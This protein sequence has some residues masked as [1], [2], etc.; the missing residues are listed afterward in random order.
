MQYEIKGSPFPV[1]ICGVNSGETIVCQKGA[2]TW[3]SSNMH[4][5]TNVGSS[6]GK[7]FGKAM[8]GESIFQNEYTA[9][10][11]F[12]E[13]AFGSSVPG[14]ILPIQISPSRTI[15]AQKT[16]FLASEK[17]VNLEVF[18]QKKIGSGFFGGEGFIMQKFSGNG[19]LFIEVDGSIIEYD[20]DPGESL[21]VDTGY[22]CA[23]DASVSIDVEMIKGVGNALFGGE[24]LF[25]TRVTGPGHVWLQ[26]MPIPQLAS[27]LRP[28][29]PTSNG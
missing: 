19:M 5:V 10:G 17:S 11:G 25:N 24:G 22:L 23:M 7:L 21:L 2:M 1:V 12:G 15:V 29:F 20:L 6:I 8:T 4:M 28:Y 16:A 3:M 26:T 13:I 9:Q 14:Q 27:S 18:F